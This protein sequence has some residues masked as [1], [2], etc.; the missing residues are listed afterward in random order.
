ML[1][2]RGPLPRQDVTVKYGVPVTS[3]AQALV[4]LAG[5]YQL[6]A[7]ERALD[8]ALTERRL[9]VAELNG[10]WP[11]S[12]LNAPGRSKIQQLLA[13][14]SEGPL[15]DTVLEAGAFEALITLPPSRPT[16]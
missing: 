3:P 1:H 13:Q 2:R 11:R 5:R 6:P 8:E 14:R 10:C 12:A 4:D 9:N 16:L 15:A 7:L